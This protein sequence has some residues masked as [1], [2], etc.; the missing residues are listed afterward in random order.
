MNP[1]HESNGNNEKCLTLKFAF[2]Q[3]LSTDKVGELVAEALSAVNTL[4]IAMG[5]LGF[6]VEPGKPTSEGFAF[7]LRGDPSDHVEITN[8]LLW[9]MQIQAGIKIHGLGIEKKPT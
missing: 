8:D 9:A 7:I 4:H 2:P 3:T 1:S 6:T 5:G